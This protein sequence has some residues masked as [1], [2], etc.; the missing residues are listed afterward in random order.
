M[1]E[2]DTSM[3]HAADGT[4]PQ[5]LD[6]VQ[7]RA[8]LLRRTRARSSLVHYAHAIDIPGD[9]TQKDDPDCEMFKPIETAVAHHHR[10]MLE[11]IQR[12]LEKDRGRGIIIGPPGMAKSTYMAVGMSWALSKWDSFLGIYVSYADD[13]AKKHSRKIRQIKRNPLENAIWEKRPTLQADQRAAEQW[14]L[15]NGSELMAAGIKSGVTGNRADALFIDDPVK[16]RKEADSEVERATIEG[17]YRDSLKTRLKP[18]G[19]II[20]TMTRWHE[21]D[22]VGNIL[23]DDYAGVSGTY[24]CKDGEDWEVLHIHAECVLP[25]SQD[26]LGRQPGQFLWP[27]WFP[28]AHWLGFKNDPRGQ[29]TWASLFQGMPTP[30][31][32]IEFQRQWFHWYD[33]DIQPGLPGGRPKY[34]VTY[35]G[36]DFA[37]SEDRSADFTEH[38]V[39]GIDEVFDF[40][41]LDWWFG[42]KESDVWIGFMIGLMRRW[43]P[44]RWWHEGGPIGKATTPAITFAM[45]RAQV[46]TVLDPLTSIDNKAVKLTSFQSRASAGAVHLPLKRPW[47]GRLVEQLIGFPAARYDDAADVCGLLGRGVDKMAG[48]HVIMPPDRPTLKPFTGE[49]LEYEESSQNQVRYT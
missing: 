33:P 29:R 7:L 48:A 39:V 11:F 8:E 2:A 21:A 18:K 41:F 38:G 15:T 45:R 17:E 26:P 49:W 31:D 27:E 40:W 44:I 35:G 32:G 4:R 47:A 34:L 13:L 10:L 1:R 36:S 14:G 19:S 37:T 25:A 42:Q 3:H 28:E 23:P 20:I 5:Q 12:V 46:F 43:K 22:L 24:R 6:E 16:G 30:G 9:P